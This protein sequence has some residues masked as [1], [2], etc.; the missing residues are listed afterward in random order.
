MIQRPRWTLTSLRPN[1]NLSP[2]ITSPTG[3]PCPPPPVLSRRN[4]LA[5]STL[6]LK[7]NHLQA[8]SP[9]AAPINKASIVFAYAYIVNGR[10]IF[11]AGGL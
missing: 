10:I 9:E 1:L 2:S 3:R 11:T 6:E 7:A 5:P 4:V 8:T